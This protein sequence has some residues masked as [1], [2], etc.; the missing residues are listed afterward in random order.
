MHWR[1]ILAALILGA[2]L[3]GGLLSLHQVARLCDRVSQPLE[4]L[5][6]QFLHRQTG[7]NALLERASAEW[8]QALP[9]LSSLISHDRL[10]GITGALFRAEGF[11]EA[12]EPGE[13]LAELWDALRQLNLLRSYD[14]PTV[15][16][17]L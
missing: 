4:Q 15:Q 11:L 3:A 14:L 17:L 16:S 7:E 12:E 8:A 9:W 2:L 10:D 5:S 6:A 13:A 1:V